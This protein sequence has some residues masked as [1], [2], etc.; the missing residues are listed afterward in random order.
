MAFKTLRDHG[1]VCDVT[2]GWCEKHQP[3]GAVLFMNPYIVTAEEVRGD[4]VNAKDYDDAL[5]RVEEG[6]A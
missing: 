2:T 5:R 4:A 3:D 1:F 6:V